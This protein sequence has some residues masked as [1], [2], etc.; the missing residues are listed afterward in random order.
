MKCY[1]IWCETRGG[2]EGGLIVRKMNGQRR[3]GDT[4]GRTLMDS[5]PVGSE[6]HVDY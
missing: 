2:V 6:S 5:V 3:T 1:K 4:S